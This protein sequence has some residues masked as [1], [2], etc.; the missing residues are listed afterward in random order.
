MIGR[1]LFLNLLFFGMNMYA[2]A[3]DPVENKTN[4][5]EFLSQHD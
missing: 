2:S 4:W 1:L 3:K 5:A